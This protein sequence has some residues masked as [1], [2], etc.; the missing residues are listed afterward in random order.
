MV[1]FTPVLCEWC[2]YKQISVSAQNNSCLISQD[3]S[4]RHSS[5]AAEW[6]TLVPLAVFF[7]PVTGKELFYTSHLLDSGNECRLSIPP[8]TTVSEL[9]NY[10]LE[11]SVWT[12]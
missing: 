12:L 10:F 6:L 1:A 5:E 2:Q 9:T 11:G 8:S 4:L 3:F 7:T